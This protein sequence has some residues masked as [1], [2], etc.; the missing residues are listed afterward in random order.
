MRERFL[1]RLTVSYSLRP[2]GDGTVYR[3]WPGEYQ[4]F[5]PDPEKPGRFRC[6]AEMRS[7]P[8]GEDLMDLMDAAARGSVVTE[9]GD[10]VAKP[11]GVVD[12]IFRTIRTV[13]SFMKG[14]AGL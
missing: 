2:V 8:G 9:N 12:N 13:Q 1:G 3:R 11:A 4:V 7:R 10:V 14:V 5:A 6:I